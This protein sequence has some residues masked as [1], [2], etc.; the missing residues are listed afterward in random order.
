MVDSLHLSQTKYINHLVSKIG[1]DTSKP[2]MTPM[3]TGSLLFKYDGKF[4]DPSSIKVLGC[5]EIPKIIFVVNKLCQFLHSSI[6]AHQKA[7][8]RVI[9]YLKESST[10]G[11]QFTK[12]DVLGIIG[13]S[14]SNLTSGPDD[15][16]SMEYTI[17]TM[18][19]I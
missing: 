14:N 6:D 3:V 15:R 11:L 1:L 2:C 16:C 12:S 5:F 19:I 4:E 9:K 17:F 8:K 18:E 10:Y 13:F 7:T